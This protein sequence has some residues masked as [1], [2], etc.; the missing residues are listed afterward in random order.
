MAPEHAGRARLAD[1]IARLAAIER[2]SA[3]AGSRRAAELIAEQLRAAGAAV[4]LEGESVHGTYWI[5]LGLLSAGGAVA[6]VLPRPARRAL[7]LAAAA[8]MVDE[9]WVG[10]QLL[11][12]R[13]R[14][15]EAV[16]VVAEFAAAAP[17]G[18]DRT[19]VVHAHHD[20]AHSGL[21]FHPAPPR[22]LARLVP[23]LQTTPPIFWSVLAG[24]LLVATGPRRLG[25]LI[26]ATTVATMRD[27][28]TATT[29][30]G[31]ND[32]LS[33]VAALVDLAQ[34]LHDDP[35]PCRVLLVSTDSEESFLEGMR[36]FV[37]RHDLPKKRT[38][39]LCL[40]SV[41]GSDLVALEGEGFLKL[42]RYPDDERERLVAAATSAG[43]AIEERFRFRFATDGQ[44]PL[45]AG[46]P[47]AV[48][49]ALDWY[50]TPRN[51]HWPTDDP[52]HVDVRT[53]ASA[54]RVAHA[55]I[56]A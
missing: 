24:P 2:P 4:R 28:A 45:L 6:A 22:L 55:F 30:P 50:R 56:G 51:Y 29:V 34:R 54:A 49:A 13:L 9:L 41:G 46:Y 17:R 40:E 25:A 39:F 47:S 35:P 23:R 8:L 1:L 44:I 16:N 14:Q 18:G 36:A 33:G 27:I 11:R 26:C 43:V 21:V 53:A 19:V 48:L 10:R 31:A 32:N 3:S 15:R 37:A 5:P 38:T 52:E 12:R 42:H 20:A 7:A